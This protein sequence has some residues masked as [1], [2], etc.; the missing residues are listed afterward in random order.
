MSVINDIVEIE[1]AMTKLRI[2]YQHEQSEQIK[3]LKELKEHIQRNT[4]IIFD[5]QKRY[6]MLKGGKHFDD[7]WTQVNEDDIKNENL[8]SVF[9]LFGLITQ[10]NIHLGT[11]PEDYVPS[12]KE[13]HDDNKTD[14]DETEYEGISQMLEPTVGCTSALPH[15]NF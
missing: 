14:D 4:K 15:H 10:R 2:N 5:L 1:E 12:R 9:P 3:M 6:D 7:K 11:P 8:L 13:E